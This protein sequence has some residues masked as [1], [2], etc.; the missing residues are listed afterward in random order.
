M[1]MLY[2]GW[3]VAILSIAPLLGLAQET[4]VSRKMSYT[5]SSGRHDG[6]QET[7]VRRELR[8]TGDNYR[9]AY[10]TTVTYPGS[11]FI[12]LFFGDTYLGDRSYLTIISEQDDDKQR[13]DATSVKDW[14]Y[15]TAYFNGDAVQIR[16]YVH[17]SDSGVYF[18]IKQI[19][20]SEEV[21]AFMRKNSQVGTNARTTEPESLC[22]ADDRVAA[23]DRAIGRLT[24]GI[25]SNCTVYIAANGAIL[26][27]GHCADLITTSDFN[28]AEFDIPRSN[29]DGTVN[30]PPAASQY[31][32]N[33]GSIRFE[34]ISGNIGNDW[35]VFW[36]N[37][38]A[39]TGLTP[40][41]GQRNFFRLTRDANPATVRIT[42]CGVDGGRDNQSLQTH[43]GPLVGE[44]TDNA[45]DI[46]FTYRVDTEP[47]NSGSPIIIDGTRTAIGIHTSG[48]CD[49]GGNRG[50]SFEADDAESAVN[51]AISTTVVHVDLNHP[52]TTQDGF[53]TRPYRSI[54]TAMANAASDALMSIAPGAYR[55][56]VT[57]RN[58]W[59]QAP[60]GEVAI[61]PN[62]TTTGR[63]GVE[64][65]KREGEVT[66]LNNSMEDQTE[67][68]AAIGR[69]YPNPFVN[70]ITAN[71]FAE[72]SMLVDLTLF[73][74]SGRQ[75]AH[76]IQHELHEAGA[77]EV[78]FDT[79]NTPAGIYIY[80]LRVGDQLTMD[81]L[82]K[83]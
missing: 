23:T 76:F 26:T 19:M 28:I 71:Y 4:T 1:N 36:C 77:Y 74:L 31:P 63:T 50:I 13:L 58:V 72:S 41:W 44:T 66:A 70:D 21:G 60:V 67:A 16:L 11:T 65:T 81:K 53:I 5:L 52:A 37:P 48:G 83:Q 25:R 43:T 32:I 12:R 6:D 7:N 33:T 17:P 69:V 27:A 57:L 24:D 47:A 42:G 61:G 30:H 10:H 35:C 59:L 46:Y 55:E 18:K 82:I 45:N 34:Y 56:T 22:G 2:C 40:G 73:D 80:H 29:A 78:R 64:Y 20:A 68:A 75:V 3:L 51:R 49:T 39:N 79:S 9:L 62:A 54:S 15:S 14:N 38:N 8:A